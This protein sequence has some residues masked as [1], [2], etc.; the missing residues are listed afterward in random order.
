VVALNPAVDADWV[1]L[2]RHPHPFRSLAPTITESLLLFEDMRGLLCAYAHG[3]MSR[4]W[5]APVQHRRAYLLPA[6]ELPSGSVVFAANSGQLSVF[7]RRGLPVAHRGFRERFRTDLSLTAT[8]AII[9]CNGGRLI[10][11]D[12]SAF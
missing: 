12:A 11:F 4:L 6:A 9:T 7:D 5:E 1:E 2:A 8:G 10:A 3:D